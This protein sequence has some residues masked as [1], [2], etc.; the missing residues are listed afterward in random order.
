MYHHIE[1]IPPEIKTGERV[2]V[3]DILGYTEIRGVMHDPSVSEAWWEI[4][5]NAKKG[6]AFRTVPPIDYFSVESREKLN[7]LLTDLEEWSEYTGEK[8][9]TITE[10]CSWI[11]YAGNE[12]WVGPSRFGYYWMQGDSEGDFVKSINSS[13]ALGDDMGRVIGPTD[14]C[15]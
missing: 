10:G 4:E 14:K 6:D 9:W 12:W 1:T 15:R 7:S 8:N 13:W 5:L 11:K 3:G 2:E